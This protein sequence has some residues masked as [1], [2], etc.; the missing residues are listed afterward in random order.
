MHPALRPCLCRSMLFAALS[1][2]SLPAQWFSLPLHAPQ[3]VLATNW[4]VAH[5]TGNGIVA[6]SAIAKGWTTISPA[7]SPIVRTSDAV[8][9]T[10]EGATTLRGWSAY[11]NASATQPVSANYSFQ[12]NGGSYAVLLDLVPATNGVL[13]GYSAFTNSWASLQLPTVPSYSVVSS[14]DGNVAVQ[15][16]GLNYHAYSAYTGQ[17]VTY[18]A[19]VAAG[20]PIVGVDYV[21]VDLQGTSGPRQYAAFSAQ[22]GTWTVSP[23]YPVAGAGPVVAQGANAFAIRTETGVASSFR[24]AGY[25]PVTGQWNTSSFVHTTASS[26]TGVAFGNVVRIQDSDVSVRFE[27]FGAG[28]GIWQHLAGGNLTE[29]A[30]RE[31]F[32][33][34]KDP[35][36]SSSTI[37]AASAL[38]GG[39]Y[40]S[41]VVPTFYPTIG[42]G[43]NVCLVSG[44]ST[45]ASNSVWGYSARTN[46]F[47]APVA[48]PLGSGVSQVVNTAVAGF[49]VQG[50][51]AFGTTAMAFTGRWGDWVAGPSISPSESWS[52]YAAKSMVLA[53]RSL[54][55]GYVVRIF[56]E[57]GDRWLPQVVNVSGSWTAGGNCFI[58]Y[59]AAGNF[60]GFSG[61]RGTWSTQSGIGAIT[62]PGGS[63]NVRENLAWFTDS[64]NLIWVFTTPDRTQTWSTWPYSTRFVTSGAAAGAATPYLG[65]SV[66]GG[67]TQYGLLYAS[68]TLP[69]SPITIPGI[70]GALDLDAG[71]V[72]QVADLGLFG[73]EGVRE[74]RIP[75]AGVVPPGL[76][77]W[78][79]AVTVD[80]LTG[81]IDLPGRSTGAVFF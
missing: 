72:V 68:L 4:Y 46:G 30:L 80:L 10:Q 35:A 20:N 33:I 32:Q 26:Q 51:S 58:T 73:A 9:V 6:L 61:Q 11:S 63:V 37:Y 22:R 56:D 2:P 39:G 60:N 66:S 78:L 43:N 81:Q 48:Q 8:V 59:D 12:S 70:G 54:Y 55:P 38:V 36:G 47:S 64:N 13:R 50:S 57:H 42:Q 71:A 53:I 67:P 16:E 41:L 29:V 5:D 1:V 23:V 74:V 65:V 31:D 40:T 62:S 44:G 28:N 14:S 27:I 52:T 25:S 15:R 7:G 77:L 69:P 45:M 75:F 21:A 17:W 76:Q 3:Q 34:V 79:Q 18:T 19:A 49:N 24:Y